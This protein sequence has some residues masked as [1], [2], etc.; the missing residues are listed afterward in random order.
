MNVLDAV[1]WYNAIPT[2]GYK[3]SSIPA[4][5]IF[6]YEVK[7]PGLQSGQQQDVAYVEPSDVCDH[8]AV[9]D[10]V[11]VKPAGAHCTT[12]WNRGTIAKIQSATN[13][14]VDGVPRHVGDLCTMP[15][16][17]WHPG[18]EDEQVKKVN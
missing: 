14:E 5:K 4:K 16:L 17:E 10:W 8:H 2:N 9:G 1:F 18:R 13:I 15:R 6:S 7:L 11:Y 3:E 12:V